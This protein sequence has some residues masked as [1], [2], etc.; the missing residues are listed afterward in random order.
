MV[1]C[2]AAL[3]VI[4][5]YTRIE[6]GK[7]GQH[8]LQQQL[9]LSSHFSLPDDTESELGSAFLRGRSRDLLY[10]LMQVQPKDIEAAVN[11]SRG[12]S[13][14]ERNIKLQRASSHQKPKMAFPVSNPNNNVAMRSKQVVA[15]GEE[16]LTQPVVT[17][18]VAIMSIYGS[19]IIVMYMIASMQGSKKDV[20]PIYV[21]LSALR[22]AGTASIK[23]REGED[24]KLL[25]AWDATVVTFSALVG[26]GALAVPY[27]FALAG[28]VAGPMVVLVTLS[29][30]FTSHLMCTAMNQ[31]AEEAASRGV[32]HVYRSW[33]LLVEA[34]FGPQWKGI[35]NMF[36]C[37]EIFGYQVSCLATMAM[38][39]N[40]V[41][42]SIS[43]SAATVVSVIAA[44][45]LTFVPPAIL[46]QVNITSNVFFGVAIVMFIA[47]GFFLPE[48]PRASDTWTLMDPH[49]L[50]A[51][52]GILIY[53]PTG[54]SFFPSV[55]QKMEQ[56]AQYSTCITKAYLAACVVYLFIGFCGYYLFG[57]FAQVSAVKN[58]GV[59][60]HLAPLPNL[61]WMNCVAAVGMTVKMS[62][63]STLQIMGLASTVEGV[64]VEKFGD[65]APKS[66]IIP[67]TTVVSAMVV[68]YFSDKMGYLLE[69]I[70]SLFCTNVGFVL[71]VACYWKLAKEP[72]GPGKRA[73]FI[74]L[75]AIGELMAVIGTISAMSGDS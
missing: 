23:K 35:L 24:R 40:Q 4:Q 56:P 43:M 33:G 62:A 58:I 14:L 75:I 15:Q 49:G 44:S 5:A 20:S 26:N 41:F 47:T 74:S 45:A 32:A 38:N 16:S 46:T 59:G 63:A 8:K 12:F 61:G 3:L 22:S 27:C 42:D 13:L 51:A 55:M 25:N 6:A 28:A 52:L 68:I 57:N 21:L 9:H 30:L 71:P 70:G 17:D 11:T 67:A 18:N 65:Q 2:L 36:V 39:L 31:Q 53:A 19:I 60:L 69:V 66:M 50:L 72:V 64:L 7:H 54:H 48:L 10:H 34:A 29:L 73:I 1:G 37:L